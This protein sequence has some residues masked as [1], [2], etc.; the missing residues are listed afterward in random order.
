MTPLQ[1]GATHVSECMCECAGVCEWVCVH[2]QAGSNACRRV[3]VTRECLMICHINCS[4]VGSV[5]GEGEWEQELK[6]EQEQESEQE[7]Q[8]ELIKNQRLYT[9]NAV[10]CD[11]KHSYLP[12]H[13][14]SG[15]RFAYGFYL[16]NFYK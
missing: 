10:S 5:W 2:A 13:I 8:V 9:F 16:A 11:P 14:V 1:V 12:P 4:S 6:R 15:N 3:L 7:Q